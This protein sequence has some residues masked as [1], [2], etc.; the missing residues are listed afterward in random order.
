VHWLSSTDCCGQGIVKSED[1]ALC[2]V[3]GGTPIFLMLWI[4]TAVKLYRE[5]RDHD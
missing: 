4:I 2:V 5:E 1:W 3:I